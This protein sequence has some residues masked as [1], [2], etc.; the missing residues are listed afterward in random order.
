MGTNPDIL[1]AVYLLQPMLV[2]LKQDGHGV[3]AQEHPGCE[4]AGETINPRKGNVGMT[5]VAEIHQ[6]VQRDMRPEAGSTHKF[7]YAESRK[8]SDWVRS[9]CRVHKVEPDDV[10]LNFA[11]RR[12]NTQGIAH[13]THAPATTNRKAGQFVLI[14]VLPGR[15]N[16]AKNCKIDILAAEL[17]GEVKAVFAEMMPTGGERCN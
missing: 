7:G 9:K 1:G 14:G 2:P 11:H 5:Q 16:I 15:V 3:G 10:G 12:Q 8:C 17:I 6:V 4:G 13:G